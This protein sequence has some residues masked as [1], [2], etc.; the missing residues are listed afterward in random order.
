[1]DKNYNEYVKNAIEWAKGHLNSKEYCFICLAFVEDALE[2]ICR[3]VSLQKELLFFM[4]V[5]E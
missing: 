1:M 4:I 3:Q 5:L 2:R